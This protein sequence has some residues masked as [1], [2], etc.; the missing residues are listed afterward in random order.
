M[1]G[2]FSGALIATFLYRA[3]TTVKEL[4]RGEFGIP[5]GYLYL[6]TARFL[7]QQGLP[8]RAVDFSIRALV[9]AP[10]LGGFRTMGSEH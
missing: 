8:P 5:N 7:R 6:G 4:P 9:L 1:V 2:S 10:V 3:Y